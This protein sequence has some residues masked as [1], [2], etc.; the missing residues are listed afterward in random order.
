VLWPAPRERLPII[1]REN[2][3]HATNRPEKTTFC[4]ESPGKNDFLPRIAWKKRLL[5]KNRLG[6]KTFRQEVSVK[7]HPC[8]LLGATLFRLLL[9]SSN[10]SV[11]LTGWPAKRSADECGRS[12]AM[13]GMA[14]IPAGEKKGI[15]CGKESPRRETFAAQSRRGTGRGGRRGEGGR[16]EE[17]KRRRGAIVARAPPRHRLHGL[18][19]SVRSTRRLPAGAETAAWPHAEREGYTPAHGRRGNGRMASRGA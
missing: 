16:G 15:P 18:T 11:G 14:T 12:E 4:H 17:E 19:R 1:A 8:R 2:G 10:G 13:R 9:H 7:Q 6:E 3:R 5:A